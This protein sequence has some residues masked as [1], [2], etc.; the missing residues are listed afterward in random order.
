L[1][2]AGGFTVELEWLTGEGE[3][4][5]LPQQPGELQPEMVKAMQEI[6]TGNANTLPDLFSIRQPMEH[7]SIKFMRP[8]LTVAGG[9]QV[10]TR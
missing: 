6:M 5:P 1:D 4:H 8:I 2:V 7:A 3:Q 10:P 9:S